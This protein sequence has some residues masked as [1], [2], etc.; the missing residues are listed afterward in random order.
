VLQV[1]SPDRCCSTRK[2]PPYHPGL[3]ACLSVFVTLVVVVLIQWANL[4]FL[5]KAQERK[6]V[7]NGK[8]AKMVDHS[9]QDRYHSLEEDNVE[10]QVQDR[11]GDNAFLDLTDRE[12][13]EFVYIY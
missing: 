13:D 9:M 3:R 6:R 5:N 12:N 1:A 11:L 8:K 7:R 4:V 10:E 2:T